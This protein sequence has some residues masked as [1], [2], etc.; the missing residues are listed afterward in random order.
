MTTRTGESRSPP[1]RAAALFALVLAGCCVTHTPRPDY[2]QREGNAFQARL[3]AEAARSTAVQPDT[4]V[5]GV[6][7]NAHG[8]KNLTYIPSELRVVHK[9]TTPVT[10]LAWDGK[11]TLEFYPREDP[12]TR[13]R[14][15]WPFA[16]KEELI[17]STTTGAIQSVTKTVRADADKGAYHFKVHLTDE[18]GKPYDDWDCPPIIIQA[19]VPSP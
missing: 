4:I 7:E 2:F 14:Q 10:W 18:N 13:R 1:N 5:I 6:L 16:E 15:N 8:G 11:F 19:P 17:E 9:E 3:R 12:K